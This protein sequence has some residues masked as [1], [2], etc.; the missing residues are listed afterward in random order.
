VARRYH[1]KRLAASFFFSR[2]GGDVGHARKFVTSIAVQLA[3]SVPAAR[4]HISDAIAEHSDIV[5]QSLHDQW[6]HLVCGPL[7]KLQLELEPETY[8]IVV[9][10]L[11]EC[12]NEY[13][14][15]II[16]RMLAE[17]RSL[18]AGVRL[19]VFLTSRPEVPIQYGFRQIPHGEH[20]DFALHRVSPLI[21]N[22]DIRLF[23]EHEFRSIKEKRRLRADW[24]GA[25]VI[26]QLVQSAS[27][28]FIWAAT[29][30]RFVEDGVTRRVMHDRLQAVLQSSGPVSEPEAH[31]DKI[32]TT[33]LTSSVP[34]TLTDKEKKEYCL[35]ARCVLG[36]IVVLL[37]PL[38]AL[39]LGR[40]LPL[41]D[42]VSED[43]VEDVL[44]GLHAILDV[45][46]S[47]AEPLRMHHPSFR[48]FL[49][50]K[51]RC[52][53]ADF[54]VEE[55]SAHERLASC[56]LELMSAPGGLRQDM[57]SLSQPGTLSS[58]I[59]EE[60]VA[61]SLPPELQYAC[62]YWIRHLVQSQQHIVDKDTTH[63]FL[64][65]HFLHWLEAMSLMRESSSCVHLLNSLQAPAGV[66]SSQNI[67]LL[68]C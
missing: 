16:V 32:Y 57:C 28:L 19:R 18:L 31:L 54:R 30:C 52:R 11:D 66:R 65:K 64:Q 13:H 1:N 7:S 12:D 6:Q 2:G 35:G 8:V 4:Q 27:R 17:V 36:S 55:T 63:L 10:A 33:V 59:E 50:S 51:D 14:I 39:S 53:D 45:P 58:E 48:D 20:Q 49:L 62:R 24:P 37:S 43:D 42:F 29:A 25:Q 9:D 38:S 56:C 3:H 44:Q 41:G 21:I 26:A 5:N 46:E 47:P 15:S 40:L 34:S 68:L 23:L 61:N 60:T 22:N 67:P